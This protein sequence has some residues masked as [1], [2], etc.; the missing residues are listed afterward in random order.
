M[1]HFIPGKLYKFTAK[2]KCVLFSE[3]KYIG[4]LQI[5]IEPND[6]V[7]FVHVEKN[8]YQNAYQLNAIVWDAYWFIHGEYRGCWLQNSDSIVDCQHVK[9]YFQGPIDYEY[10]SRQP[11]LNR[12]K[13]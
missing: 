9:S 1:T 4:A 13:T 5:E 11:Q 10:F 3:A 12:S 7:M 2:H 6:I 8:A